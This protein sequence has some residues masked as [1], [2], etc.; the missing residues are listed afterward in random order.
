MK[1]IFLDVDGVLNFHDTLVRDQSPAS[2]DDDCVKRLAKIV[3][4]DDDVR[5]V[6]S[7]TW[8]HDFRRPDGRFR[9]KLTASLAQEG[10]EIFDM[11]PSRMS[12][13]HRG[14]EIAMWLEDRDDVEEFVILDDD[15]DM[16]DWQTPHFVQTSFAVEGGPGGLQDEHVDA[17]IRILQ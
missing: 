10:L 5:I 15:S 17:A 3:A 7:S 11:T 9:N 2:I 4:C 12:M 8:R 6:L 13:S 16:H 1:V 14:S